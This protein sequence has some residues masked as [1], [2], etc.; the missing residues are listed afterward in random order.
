MPVLLVQEVPDLR[1][2]AMS[3]RDI[4]VILHGRKGGAPKTTMP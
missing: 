1:P 4:L 3:T 2:S